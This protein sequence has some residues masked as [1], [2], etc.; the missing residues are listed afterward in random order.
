MFNCFICEKPSEKEFKNFQ[1]CYCGF[2]SVF[3]YED[4]LDLTV[5]CSTSLFSLSLHAMIYESG[6]VEFRYD[7]GH[8]INRIENYEEIHENYVEIRNFA[9]MEFLDR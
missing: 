5:K 4:S 2:V 3:F 9:L 7:D 1:K 8:Y 6:R